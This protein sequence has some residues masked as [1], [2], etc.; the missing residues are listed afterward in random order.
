M[1]TK[2]KFCDQRPVAV[3]RA[4][5]TEDCEVKQVCLPC[6][7]A[8]TVI[9]P[10]KSI[11]YMVER[12][13]SGQDVGTQEEVRRAVDLMARGETPTVSENVMEI[14]VERRYYKMN[15]KQMGDYLDMKIQTTGQSEI[16]V[17]R[18]TD[19]MWGTK[20]YLVRINADTA[21]LGFPEVTYL[22]K[23]SSPESSESGTEYEC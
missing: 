17:V 4:S 7:Q 6:A 9:Y 12:L 22:E 2:C 10:N 18:Q 13:A 14:R 8:M 11:S 5:G 15:E 3:G 21:G 1:Q 16:K 20:S 19:L 23:V